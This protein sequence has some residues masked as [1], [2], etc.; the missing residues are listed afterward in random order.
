MSL[1]RTPVA[2]ARQRKDSVLWLSPVVN[3]AQFSKWVTKIQPINCPIAESSRL[4]NPT[5]LHGISWSQT[6]P[7]WNNPQPT[8]HASER[9]NCGMWSHKLPC[10]YDNI[11]WQHF[12]IRGRVWQ[13]FKNSQN[14]PLDAFSSSPNWEDFDTQTRPPFFP[15]KPFR[16]SLNLWT[17]PKWGNNF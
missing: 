16:T 15:L 8:Q 3:H 6:I 2:A 1:Q 5:L 7:P 11:I 14:P 13:N 4:C 10:V 17:K 9:E 12:I